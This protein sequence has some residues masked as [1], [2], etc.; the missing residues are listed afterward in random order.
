MGGA[1]EAAAVEEEAEGLMLCQRTGCQ[2]RARYGFLCG[3]HAI[4][5]LAALEDV[6]ADEM[7]RPVFGDVMF[8]DDDW[9]PSVATSS[10]L[11]MAVQI[12]PDS[13]SAVRFM[14]DGRSLK[15]PV[16]VGDMETESSPSTGNDF[17]ATLDEIGEELGCSRERVRQIIA[18][19]LRKLRHPSRL[20]ALRGLIEGKWCA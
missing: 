5:E 8:V 3:C 10:R 6:K 4:E 13:K 16:M 20:K 17:G 19:A 11:P 12:R 18:R 15:A 2:R 7:E 9:R 14:R 1:G